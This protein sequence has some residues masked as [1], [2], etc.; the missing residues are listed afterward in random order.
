MAAVEVLQVQFITQVVHASA[1]NSDKFPQSEGR[2]EGASG[3]VP[4][5]GGYSCCAADSTGAVLVQMQ[6]LGSD[7]GTPVQR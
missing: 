1:N 2:F 5:G 4:Q 6:L 7:R 3:S